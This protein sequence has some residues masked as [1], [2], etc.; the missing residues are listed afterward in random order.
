MSGGG[1]AGLEHAQR[2][3]ELDLLLLCGSFRDQGHG[4]ISHG[5]GLQIDQSLAQLPVEVEGLGREQ[6]IKLDDELL[7]GGFIGPVEPVEGDLGG[8]HQGEL[9]LMIQGCPVELEQRVEQFALHRRIHGRAVGLAMLRANAGG[10]GQGH[11]RLHLL[12]RI[13]FSERFV[14]PCRRRLMLD[15]GAC[16]PANETVGMPQIRPGKINRLGV[17]LAVES[18]QTVA[19]IARF[20]ALGFGRDKRR[21]LLARVCHPVHA[22]LHPSSADGEVHGTV[23]GV[24]DRIGKR[25]RRAGDELLLRRRVGGA[26]GLQMNRIQFA[27]APIEREH[28]ILVPGGEFRAI[29]E[30]HASG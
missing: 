30:G 17:L 11:Q 1:P 24:N 2:A 23:L 8:P 15:G 27:P 5:G 16:C 26:L 19:Q 22:R 13:G 3:G 25:Q 18:F 10:A 21:V 29:A 7:H 9:L 6:R 20:S 14:S 4:F 28:R 12:A